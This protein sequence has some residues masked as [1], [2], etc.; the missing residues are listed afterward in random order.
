MEYCAGKFCT[1]LQFLRELSKKT[2]LTR[3]KDTQ[4]S[5]IKLSQ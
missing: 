3:E 4:M 5:L 1:E 2:K